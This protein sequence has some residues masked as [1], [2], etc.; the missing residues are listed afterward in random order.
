MAENSNAVICMY[1]L[2]CTI[3]KCKDAPINTCV[4]INYFL[5]LWKHQLPFS[6]LRQPIKLHMEQ[7]NPK[8]N[9]QFN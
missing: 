1:E 9:E 6:S 7:D 5:L 3:S 2:K 4:A 8:I